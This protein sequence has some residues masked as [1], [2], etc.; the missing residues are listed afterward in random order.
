[1]LR[2]TGARGAL[3]AAALA[4]AGL[5]LALTARTVLLTVVVAAAA[6]L[7]GLAPGL[8]AL[9]AATEAVLGAAVLAGHRRL[10]DLGSAGAD[11][12]DG[13]AR[14]GADRAVA[15][16]VVEVRLLGPLVVRRPDGALV[17]DRDWR[18]AKNLELLRLLALCG[19]RVRTDE[20]V[21]ALWPDAPP[22][23]AAASLRTA[24]FELRRLLG[25]DHV[26][27]AGEDLVLRDTWVD[28]DAYRTLAVQ[29]RHAAADG[30]AASCL[31]LA[32]QAAA[33]HLGPVAPRASDGLA[34]V[35]QV[36]ALEALRRDV[37]L[38]AGQA[39]LLV[40]RPR[41]T[42]ALL[43]AFL[44][45]DPLCE[46][47]YRDLMEAHAA[48]GETGHALATYERCR[49]VL[50]AELGADPSPLTRTV[51]LR[52][53]AGPASTVPVVPAGRT[54][55]DAGSDL[56]GDVGE[57]LA[58]LRRVHAELPPPALEA[59]HLL[60]VA[61]VPVP[62]AALADL[63]GDDAVDAAR[64]L[65]DRGLLAR[66]DDGALEL[67]DAGLVRA[68]RDW[69]RPRR[70]DVLATAVAAT[71]RAPVAPVADAAQ[72]CAGAAL[73]AALAGDADTAEDLLE[74]YEACLGARAERPAER[75]W[76]LAVTA[77]VREARGRD[78]SATRA[79]AQEVAQANGLVR[80]PALG[81]VRLAA[82]PDVVAALPA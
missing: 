8:L 53:L 42:V 51:H 1:M 61:R 21:A 60:A 13:A 16:D 72:A 19:G 62:A 49:R 2:R 76:R 73:R 77:A 10:R 31:E 46:R 34:V 45:D 41:R 6:L 12:A 4:A 3:G 82:D 44:A 81:V 47:A 37:V 15:A 32:R 5:V 18:G 67:A 59:F 22:R 75:V 55:G 14:R 48:L 29:A 80:H 7:G 43:T 23:R 54:G 17:G 50:A 20:A 68:A 27:R 33:L 69:L 9:D 52:L 58:V 64:R 74:Q 66:R 30:L 35:E 70:R 38:D 79:L 28:V 26:V 40:G 63:L 11:A 25:P 39:A 71:L 24:L 78:G 65:A 56:V 57:A 36:T